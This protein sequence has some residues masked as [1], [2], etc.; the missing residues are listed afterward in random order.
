MKSPPGLK[1]LAGVSSPSPSSDAVG[2]HRQAI[3]LLQESRLA[4]A[5]AALRKALELAPDSAAVRNDLA[6]L[7]S[8]DGRVDQAVV[9]LELA[10]R[11][12]PGNADVQG[13]LG[14]LYLQS[15]QPDKALRCLR[16]CVELRPEAVEGYLNLSTLFQSVGQLPET[17]RCLQQALRHGPGSAEIWHRLG[18]TFTRMKQPQDA[19][20]SYREALRLRPTYPEAL[21]NLGALL[22]EQGQ[23]EEAVQCLR[24]SLRIRPGAAKTLLNLGV[25]LAAQRSTV[26]AEACYR[27]VLRLQ[28]Q[29]HEAL[30]NLGN[31]LQSQ[32]RLEEALAVLDEALRKKPDYVEGHNN[33]GIALLKTGDIPAALG[34]F[35]QALVLKPELADTHLNRALAWLA[36][37]KYEQGWTEYEWRWRTAQLKPR[38]LSQPAW[39][40]SPL[41]G[42]T[43]LVHAEQG[44]GDLFQFVRYARLVK[45]RG[46]RVLLECPR[47][48]MPILSRC[49]GIDQLLGLGEPLPAFDV[50]TPLL[51]LPR[52][53]GTTLASIP[54]AVPYLFADPTLGAAWRAELARQGGFK[55]GIAWQGS[56]T[57]V[58]D[59]LRSIPLKQFAPLAAIP[60]VTLI[61]LQK[62]PGE[63]QLA[64]AGFPVVSF[65]K[66]LDSTS[67]AFMDSAALLKELDLVVVSDSAIAHLAGGLGVPVWLAVPFSADWRWLRQREDSPWYPTMRLFRQQKLGDWDEVF[68]RIAGQLRSRVGAA[69]LTASGSA[70]REDY[71][72][73]MRLLAEKKLEEAAHSLRR[74]LQ[75]APEHFE[76]RQNLG[77]LLVRLGKVDEAIHL[78]RKTLEGRP[79]SSETHNN[80]G[81]AYM[82]KRQTGEAIACFRK[83]IALKE[84]VAEFH[85]NLGTALLN[86]KEV[87]QAIACFQRAV[88]LRPE[89]VD[90]RCNLALAYRTSKQPERAQEC[91]QEALRLKPD[92]PHLHNEL[93]LSLI[94]QGKH[95]QAVPHLQEAVRLKPTLQ[96]AWNNLGVVLADLGRIPEATQTFEAALLQNPEHPETHRNLALTLLL[97]GDYPRGFAELEWRWKC[98]K[99]GVRSF[100][101]PLWDGSPLAGRTILLHAEQ[102]LGDTLQLIRYAPRIKRQGATVVL[103]C[104][105]PLVRLLSRCAGIDQLLERG[106]PLPDFDV[107]S[108]LMSL[109]GLLGTTVANI[110]AEV[111]YIVPDQALVQEWASYLQTIPGFKVGIVWQGNP[112]YGGDRYRSIPLEHFS[113]L[114]D[115]PGVRLI[116]LQKGHGTEQIGRLPRVWPLFDLDRQMDQARGGFMDT[117]AVLANL[118][119]VVTSDTAM[120]HLAGALG[121]PVWM[122]VGT[123]CDWRWKRGRED[124]P[125][126]PTVRLFRQSQRGQ[127][128]DVFARIAEQLRARVDAWRAG[129]PV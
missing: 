78:L 2:M 73:G 10:L 107:H 68:Q 115:I 22:R 101:R 53:L 12:N 20:A 82:Q 39:D 7:L 46:G 63:E 110:P 66:R 26:E 47:P 58:D 117:A 113:V 129:P 112:K 127:W 60:G 45:E 118:D 120:P 103:E 3:G 121:V 59:V 9:L 125:W 109:P 32:G 54:A 92:T 55:V 79:D 41:A 1:L 71:E 67:G 36:T 70:G 38:A 17:L 106:A 42:R 108:P 74:A 119:L 14:L 128:Q 61:A 95:E 44:I 104:Q 37:G 23:L 76:A 24:E 126:Y 122:A 48:L 98:P 83:A 5:E 81:L 99:S 11:D 86:H 25:A 87:D 80:L 77:V 65:G 15:G 69:P 57:Y 72:R 124:S 64:S 111:P 30:N 28:P 31:L 85:N 93:A 13:N 88:Q 33:R 96:D 40:G 43:I 16:R 91:Y 100:S 75:A 62:G 56:P 89:A 49:P 114:G 27:E 84:D 97:Q 4:E 105:K 50:H 102:G 94:S 123:S 116:S 19:I 29:S 18:L 52:L 8:R 51:S 34:A 90:M 6:V 35:D 21:N